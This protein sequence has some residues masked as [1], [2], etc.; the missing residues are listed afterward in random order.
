MKKFIL[1]LFFIGFIFSGNVQAQETVSVSI[2]TTLQAAL[3]DEG[4]D[5]QDLGAISVL[6]VT[7]GTL[8]G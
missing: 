3:T 4:Y 5:G 6:I 1:F 2:T 7:G 8:R